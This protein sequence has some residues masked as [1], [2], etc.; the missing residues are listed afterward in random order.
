MA[1]REIAVPQHI[2]IL[3]VEQE[4]VGDDTPAVEMVLRADVWREHLLEKE[5]NITSRMAAIDAEQG[6]E[7]IDEDE[8]SSLENEKNKLNTE[9]QEVF[10]KLSDI[11]SDK[12][13]NRQE[14]SLVVGE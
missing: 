14:N 3:Y 13:E 12:A 9:L 8:K 7:D 10:S 4:V 11:E 1:R 2:S 6:R 5:R